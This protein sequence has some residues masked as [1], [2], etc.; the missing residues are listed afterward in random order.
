MVAVNPLAGSP[1][2]AC[3]KILVRSSRAL[4]ANPKLA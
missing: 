4:T 2:R 3:S 1:L